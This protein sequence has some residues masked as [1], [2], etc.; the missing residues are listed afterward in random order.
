METLKL[1]IRQRKILR[2]LEGKHSYVTSTELAQ[3]MKVSSR[4]IRNDI[5]EMEQLLEPMDIHILS[6][7]SKGFY[8]ESR[9]SE[10]I[11]ELSRTETALFSRTERIRYLTFRLCGSEDRLNLYDLEDEMFLSRT[12][13]LSDLK[14]IQ[15]K[16]SYQPPYI[17]RN[18]K[19]DEIW[20]DQDEYM[21]RFVLLNLF[22]EDWDYA[23]QNNA[24]YGADFLDRNLMKSLISETTGTLFRYGI[25]MDDA[26]LAALQL[27]LG[28]MHDRVING[29]IFPEGLPLPDINT[30]IGKAVVDLFEMIKK[31]TGVEYPESEMARINQFIMETRI[32]ED[33]WIDEDGDPDAFSDEVRKEVRGYLE[34]INNVFKVDFSDDKEFTH[35][36]CVYFSQIATG[37]SMFAHYQDPLKIKNTL[38][39]EFELAYL[40]QRR[41]ISFM[42]RYLSDSELCTLAVCFSGAIRQYL[43]IHP[44]KKLH[45]VLFSHGN[46][47]A[48][49][50]LKRRILESFDLYLDITDIAPFNFAYSFD[51]DNVDIIFSTQKKKIAVSS[52]TETIYIDDHP[53]VNFENDAKLIKILSFKKIWPVS[54]VTLSEMLKCAF[55][56]ENEEHADKRHI[57][58]SMARDYISCGI[59]EEKHLKDILHRES[60][61]SFAIKPGLVLVFTLLP[62][63]ET[64]LSVMSLHHRVRWNDFKISTVIMA[65]FAPEDINLL[66]KLKHRFCIDIFDADVLKKCRTREELIPVLK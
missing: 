44:E 52:N 39:A 3:A 42:E 43:Q 37:N 46:L 45:A 13:L 29:H 34:D 5:H 15:K 66:F 62:V 40:Y 57:I 26:T 16:Y 31:Q 7:Q 53:G 35:V 56:H 50:G 30:E 24:L 10:K 60:V 47:A 19:G 9:D 33:R 20:F 41:A 64:R 38:T 36:L 4:T 12:A 51:F 17:K 2:I 11:R 59:A 48:A 28:I 22:H 6:V 1:S 18:I 27:L 54:S 58:E 63:K 65:M 61:D 55:W 14:E 23:A 8:I 32:L 25:K 49:F 21:I